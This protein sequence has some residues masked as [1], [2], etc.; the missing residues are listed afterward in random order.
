MLIFR[1]RATKI[2]TEKSKS[3]TKRYG[4]EIL[5]IKKIK[6]SSYSLKKHDHVG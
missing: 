2:K 4:H 3:E 1:K 5:E 6:I